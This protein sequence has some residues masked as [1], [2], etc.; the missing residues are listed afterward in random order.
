MS[1]VQLV[2]QFH[3]EESGQDLLEY[4]LVLA[5]VAAAAVTGSSSLATTITSAL[6]K[7][8]VKISSIVS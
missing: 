4:A 5:A 1:F 2:R 8:N 3:N 6:G 7:L